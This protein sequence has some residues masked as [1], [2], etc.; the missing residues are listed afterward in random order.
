M[1]EDRFQSLPRSLRDRSRAERLA[2]DIPALLAH[3]DWTSPA[4]ACLWL[5]GRTVHKEL[6]PGRYSR[7]LRA[8]IA[9]CAIDLPGHGERH[10]EDLQNP[11]RSLDTL[12]RTIGEID[13][14]LDALQGGELAGL[15]DPDRLAIGGMSLGGMA[16]LRR[17]CDDHLF[18]AAAVEATTGWLTELYH[19]TL[20]GHAGAPW[21]VEHPRDRLAMLDPNEHLDTWRPIPLLALHTEADEMV[22]WPSQRAFLDRLR[23]RYR[24]AGADPSQIEVQTWPETGA[25]SEHIGFGREAAKAK[26]LQAAF[27]ARH[28]KA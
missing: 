25:P 11:E 13:L 1:V 21:G 19:P 14:V 9:V 24:E 27:L 7:W 20:E 6:D 22:P 10:D 8:G 12:E 5:H 26:D 15:F 16:T 28:L 4:P 23:E 18:K 2:G 3:P 17:L